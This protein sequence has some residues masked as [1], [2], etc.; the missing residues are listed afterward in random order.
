[1]S[2]VVMSKDKRG[3]VPVE[4]ADTGY[5]SR[6]EAGDPSRRRFIRQITVGASATCL[7]GL[8]ALTHGQSVPVR[9]DRLN[10]HPTIERSTSTSSDRWQ[11]A[12][13][14]TIDEQ[15]SLWIEPGFVLLLEWTRPDGN[16]GPIAALEGATETV[17]AHLQESVTSVDQL[18]NLDQL[19]QIESDLAT[20]L[21]PIVAPA[22]IGLLHL[23]HDCETVCNDLEPSTIGPVHHQMRGDI[24]VPI[25]EFE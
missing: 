20:L 9:F 12:Q 25:I 17:S 10:G 8:P 19:H 4:P 6:K 1:M 15:R 5:P 3:V 18:H 24:P 21:E 11:L 14:T 7:V 2:G 22:E 16:E 13:I 23:D